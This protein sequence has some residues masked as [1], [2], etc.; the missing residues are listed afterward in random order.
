MNDELRRSGA[1]PVDMRRFRPNVVVSGLGGGE[2]GF[3][4]DKWESVLAGTK[5]VF[6]FVKPCSRCTVTTVDQDTGVVKDKKEPLGA[7][8]KIHSG[9]KANYECEKWKRQ[10]FFGWNA[11]ATSASDSDGAIVVSLNDPVKVMATR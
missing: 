9:E 3:E 1:S 4:E 5:C 6:D 11:V 10:Q 2:E 7:L 8:G